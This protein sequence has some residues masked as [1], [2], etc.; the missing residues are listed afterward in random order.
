VRDP[1]TLELLGDEINAEPIAGLLTVVTHRPEFL[2]PWPEYA[3]VARITLNRL[4]RGQ[5]DEIVQ[6]LPHDRHRPAHLKKTISE[7]TD[8]I[9]LF[10]E[11]LTQ[12]VIEAG[13][14]E[15]PGGAGLAMQEEAI[16]AKLRDWLM[17]R[18]DRLGPASEVAQL[19]AAIGRDV[20]YELLRAVS[21]REEPGL[22]AD[23]ARLVE[24]GL[25]LWLLDRREEARAMSDSAIAEA[26]QLGHPFTL[27]LALCFEAWLCQFSNDTG[28]TKTRAAEALAFSTEQE[29]PFWIGWAATLEG[30]AQVRQGEVEA[31]T[32]QMR[33]GL[34]DWQS[35]GSQLGKTYFLLLLA[36]GLRLSDRPR[37]A[38]DTLDEALRLARET[39]EGFCPSEI[40]RFQGEL[41]LTSSEDRA[42]AEEA[43][44]LAVEVAREQGAVALEA[45][46]RRRLTALAR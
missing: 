14:A 13:T 43:I 21:E 37:E 10:V 5:V 1:T 19:A 26:R 22:Q 17:A 36:D 9:P 38:L 30:W 44:R 2:P 7:R 33:Q 41:L 35:T 31:G 8:G 3:H 28:A 6:H 46:A 23:L 11:E 32:A 39:G 16:P 42:R 34:V 20:P 15:V 24:A 18:L 25:I 45:R 12:T 27:A 29:F 4:S 40:H